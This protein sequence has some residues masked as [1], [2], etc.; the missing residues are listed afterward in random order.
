MTR[1]YVG[2][3]QIVGYET[4]VGQALA[5]VPGVAGGM[6][7]SIVPRGFY[8]MASPAA[9]PPAP[10][11]VSVPA[12]RAREQVLGLPRTSVAAN[13]TDEVLSR[14]EITFRPSRLLVPSSIA[15]FFLIQDIKV[16]NVSQLPNTDPI[17]AAGYIETAVGTAMALD[18][19]N[20]GQ[21][22]SVEVTNISACTLDFVGAFWGTAL[23]PAL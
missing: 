23:L 2:Y 20:I 4:I 8:P 21:S 7:A 10:M 6:R 14:P 5:P 19:C 1:H 15:A 13:T 17:P 18:T 22:I 12:G 11:A 9:P 16:G 3:D